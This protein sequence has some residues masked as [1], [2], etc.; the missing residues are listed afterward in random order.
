MISFGTNIQSPTDELRQCT[1]LSVIE[2][3]RNPHPAS[4]Q[5]LQQLR[6]IY[7]MDA[8]Q[9]TQLKR[10]LPYIVCGLFLPP[11]RKQENF[12]YAHYFCLDIDH[13]Q[14][15][16]TTPKQLKQT[17]RQDPRVCAMYISP[18]EDGLKVFFAFDK[19]CYDKGLYSTFYKLF[20]KKFS[21]QYHLEQ[22]IDTRTSDVTRACFLSADA[23]AYYNENA[24]KVILS[25]YV[26]VNDSYALQQELH[27]I[28][29][30]EKAQQE[31]SKTT[32]PDPDKDAM[33]R[34]R[35]TLNSKACKPQ[36]PI[37]VPEILEE[38]IQGLHDYI[39]SLGIDVVEIHNIQYA[40]KITCKLHTKTAEVNLFYGKH[41]FKVVP[42]PKSGT[43][44]E[45][46][47]LMVTVVQNYINTL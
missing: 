26:N 23:D 41:G 46:M 40:K 25:D 3:V 9:Y 15:K 31:N 17:L 47:N 42:S 33:Q 5:H 24:T 39:V 7:Q 10:T 38:I 20:A 1:L 18:I 22:V 37:Y 16:N 43:D 34:I 27:E 8:S 21:E 13:L 12:A 35:Q 19:P 6:I 29:Q 2:K 30:Q 4:L 28:K 11:C 45:L 36:I 14:E 44:A 32:S